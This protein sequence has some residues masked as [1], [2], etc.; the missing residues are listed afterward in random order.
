VPP[1]CNVNAIIT[2]PHQGGVAKPVPKQ[3]QVNV[4]GAPALRITDMPGTPIMPGCPNLPTP[5]TPTFVPC[6]TIVAPAAMGSTKVR[7]G[8]VPALLS[9]SLMTTNCV[10]P[11]PNGA[12]VKSPG[13]VIVNARG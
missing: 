10:A 4:G 6:A 9:T 1:I 11:V 5:G 2:C 12:T 3:V 13:Q 8:G 7:I